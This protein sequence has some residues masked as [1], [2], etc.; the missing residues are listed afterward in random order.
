MS[1]KI[2]KVQN[3]IERI[4][5]R[6]LNLKTRQTDLE[7]QLV[8]LQNTEIVEMVRSVVATPEE[9]AAFIKVF[10]EQAGQAMYFKLREEPKHEEM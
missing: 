3:E 1:P 8:E 4:E 9:L 7:K 10:R 5:T 2:A 6:I